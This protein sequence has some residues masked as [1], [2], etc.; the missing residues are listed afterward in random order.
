MT[1]CGGVV[2]AGSHSNGAAGTLCYSIAQFIACSV[3]YK[4]FHA[5]RV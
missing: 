5:T 4:M 1:A 3:H 2:A